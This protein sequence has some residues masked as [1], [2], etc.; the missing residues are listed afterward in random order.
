MAA[1]YTYHLTIFLFVLRPSPSFRRC[2]N[3][4][5]LGRER[6]SSG[7]GDHR[8]QFVLNDKHSFRL[9]P[10][11]HRVPR[12]PVPPIALSVPSVRCPALCLFRPYLELDIGRIFLNRILC[13]DKGERYRSRTEYD[14]V[15]MHERVRYSCVTRGRLSQLC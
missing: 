12:T 15:S 5:L 9:S 11:I 14:G 6:P 7:R 8:A 2:R 10:T 13:A 4:F 3:S 1:R